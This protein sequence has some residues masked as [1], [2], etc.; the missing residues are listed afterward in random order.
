MARKID[1]LEYAK[2]LLGQALGA[3]MNTMPNDRSVLEAKGYIKQAINK[4]DKVT[5]TQK[6]KKSM[7]QTRQDI[8]WGDIQA[9]TTNM[10]EMPTSAE[11]QRKS[12][13]QLNAMIDDEQKKIDD[14][15]QNSQPNELLQD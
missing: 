6:K 2:D 5:E 14:I 7:T 15:E 4:L 3:A 1:Q 13:D 11:A 9:G 12:L 8:W 10:A